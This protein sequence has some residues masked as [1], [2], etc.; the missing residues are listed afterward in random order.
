[1]PKGAIY[2]SAS[3]EAAIQ[4]LQINPEISLTAVAKKYVIPRTSLQYE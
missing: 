4:E 2:V 1:M 3:M